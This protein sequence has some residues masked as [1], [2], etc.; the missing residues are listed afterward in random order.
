MTYHHGNIKCRSIKWFSQK[1]RDANGSNSDRT[2]Q[3]DRVKIELKLTRSETTE[4]TSKFV[5]GK[6]LFV[7][8]T[9]H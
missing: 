8:L 7:I 3:S 2:C 6:K 4:G 9:T 5:T 1:R